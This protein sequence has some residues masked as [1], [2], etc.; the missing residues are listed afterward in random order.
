MELL[1]EGGDLANHMCGILGR[2]NFDSTPVMQE[3]L[4]DASKP[5]YER[6]PDDSGV[7]VKNECGLAHLRLSILD[8]S[9]AGH[10][11]MESSDGRYVGVYNGEIYNF[12]ELR[13][14]LGKDTSFWR[15][16]SDTEVLIEGWAIWGV[17]LLNRID[18]MFAFAIW[19]QYEKK[20]F[21]AR[22]RVGE[23]PFYY[24][25]DGKHFGFASRPTP[26]FKMFP[27]LSTEYDEQALRLFLEAGY[28]PA[29]YSTH[30]TV[31]KLKAAHYLE[32]STD[33]LIQKPYSNYFSIQP[34]TSW[35]RRSED[36]LLDELDEILSRSVRKRMVSDVPIG[37]FLSG[38]IDSTLMVAMMGKY[39]SNPVNTFT[40]GFDEEAYDESQNAQQV[41]N[42]LFTNH[43][44]QH[45]SVNDL[46][47]LM[48]DFLKHY[49]E[50]FFDSAAFPTMA[51]SRLA[52]EHVKVSMTG[53]GGDELFGG[54]HYYQII[55]LLSPFF[56][57]PASI[58]Q[59]LGKLIR[60]LPKHNFKLLG[61]ALRQHSS[62]R[63]FAFS[64]SIAKDFKKVLPDNI[65]KRTNGIGDLF[66]EAASNFPI[67]LHASEEAMRLD[68][69]YTLNDDYL[70]K[71]DVASMAF[72][73]ESRAP[74]LSREVIEWSL[75]L[76]V[77]WKLKR[78][79]S[80]Y[81]L[82]KLSYRYV[83]RAIMDR[84]KR[85]FGVPIDNWLRNDLSVWAEDKVNDS[86]NFK[87]LPLNQQS[88]KELFQLHKSGA[89]NAHPL[90]W[91]ILMLLEFNSKHNN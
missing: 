15:G 17:D 3:A 14:L 89:R 41:A 91:A 88:T 70:Q 57:G 83:P 79:V 31:R 56:S 12:E 90:L 64:R 27:G 34:E 63:A 40:I 74:I 35:I 68:M 23:K 72:S 29:P 73:L 25:W 7:W 87:G 44:C 1:P 58:R 65:I 24:H 39:S 2:I 11:P 42:H 50:P 18:G 77:D 43:Y 13:V 81:L 75:K 4:V 28:I 21:A 9:S 85:G 61:A 69:L 59:N 82:R 37:A 51:V 45:L 26:I 6:G 49:D 48:P 38:G 67:G 66:E 22:D 80:K 46:L 5:I 84:P 32:V 47:G 10:Q 30:K 86:Q 20:L 36:D 62:A 54:Y 78:G 33:G 19:D 53:D 55:R 16:H 8:L 76:P 52:R 71:T 60:L